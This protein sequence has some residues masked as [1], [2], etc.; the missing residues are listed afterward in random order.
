M[1]TAPAVGSNEANTLYDYVVH[2]CHQS[3]QT[4]RSFLHLYVLGDESTSASG[5]LKMEG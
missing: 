1:Y 2:T 5:F 3:K 4:T